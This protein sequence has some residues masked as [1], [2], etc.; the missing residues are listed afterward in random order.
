MCD[1]ALEG[2]GRKNVE[3]MVAKKF[4]NLMKTISPQFQRPTELWE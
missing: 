1:S 3:E 2:V 4:P